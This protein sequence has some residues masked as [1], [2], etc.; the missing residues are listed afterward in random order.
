MAEISPPHNLEA[1]TGLLACCLLDRPSLVSA[2]DM[3]IT[4][5][6]F[7]QEAHKCIFKALMD[8]SREDEGDIHEVKLLDKLAE[9]GDEERVGGIAYIYRIQAAIETPIHANYF[10]RRVMDTW[11]QR[12]LIRSCRKAIEACSER[13]ANLP[14]ITNQLEHDVKKINDS[15]TSKGDMIEVSEAAEALRRKIIENIN[16]PDKAVARVSTPL[17]DLNRIL[18]GR[19]FLPGQLII[20]AA[21]PSLGK[22]SLAINIAEKCAVDDDVPVLIF[23]LEMSP[24]ELVHR[25]TCSR[26]RVN[27]KQL[28]DGFL[29][30]DKVSKFNACLDEIQKSKIMFNK[31]ASFNILKICANAR[32]QAN[33]AERIGQK[34][35]L[36]I[37][38]YLQ[39]IEGTDRKLRR[40]QQ[41]AEMSRSLKLLAQELEVPV[42][43]LSQLNRSGEKEGRKPKMS[44]LR[45]SGAIE[46]DADIVL[47]LHRPDQ[48]EYSEG[49]YPDPNVEVIQILHEKVR[50]GPVGVIESTFMRSYTRFENYQRT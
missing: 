45:E 19:G 28:E 11:N 14:E 18:P 35:G 9:Y 32:R 41:I 47:L 21:R 12:N 23:S 1:E 17:A 5:E 46:Q 7:F 33:Q 39:L 42:I 3:G 16:N 37:I 26:S 36:I 6:S 43:A 38:D 22:T 20:L 8:I 10:A 13:S 49:V 34:I 27:S 44:D 48:S 31:T 2:I 15:I 25:A 29:H 4:D 50:N 24:Q 40:E 30:H